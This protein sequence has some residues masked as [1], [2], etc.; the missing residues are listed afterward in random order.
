MENLL[1]KMRMELEL[2]N[3]SPRTIESYISYI[4]AYSKFYNLSSY[5]L[6]ENEI[7]DYFYHLRFRKKSSWSE[8]NGAYSS[9]KFFYVHVLN[10]DWN[11]KKM[12]RPKSEKKLP[13]VLSREEVKLILNALINLKHRTILM[14]I[15]SA[16]L[17]LSEAANLKISDIDSKRML[18]K[19]EQGKGRKDRYTLLSPLL[20]KQLRE[21]YRWYHPKNWLFEGITKEKPISVRSIQNIFKRAKVK[22]GIH[23]IA[24]IHTM[25]H[26]FAT[27]LIE[28]GVDVFTLQQLLGHKSL[29]TTS[30][31]VHIQK[32]SMEKI[33]NPLDLTMKCPL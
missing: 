9:L 26:S 18:I 16:G 4:V 23:K 29:R 14:T 1:E 20:L 7:R 33:T 2:M 27:H 32:S 6:D 12:P 10:K 11:V 5:F 24:T 25:R 22:A 13:L 17:R 31:Y 15:Y 30:I 28:Q 3:Y 8:V 19:V 21:Y